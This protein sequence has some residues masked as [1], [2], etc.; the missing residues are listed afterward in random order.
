MKGVFK[1]AR[2]DDERRYESVKRS[3]MGIPPCTPKKYSRRL[4]RLSLGM[5]PCIPFSIKNHQ[6]LLL[7]TIFLSLH[8][9]CA[10][11][12]ASCIYFLVYLLLIV[13]HNKL[14]PILHCLGEKRAP[15]HPRTQHRFSCLS[16]MCVLYLFIATVMLSSLFSCLFLFK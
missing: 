1:C 4:K 6:F 8:M 13:V 12:G 9:L 14:D 15:L 2:E 11:L 3:S 5:P 7:H 16:L 10:I